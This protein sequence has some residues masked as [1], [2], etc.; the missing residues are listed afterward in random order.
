MCH[1][2]LGRA[3]SRAGEGVKKWAEE[4]NNSRKDAK[5]QR[6]AKQTKEFSFALL[7]VFAPLRVLIS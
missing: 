5:A 3:P 6:V 4:Q 2:H 7:R 1:G